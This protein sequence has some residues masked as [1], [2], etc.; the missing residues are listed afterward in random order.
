MKFVVDSNVLFTFFW[1][2]SVFRNLPV[3]LDLMLYSP[4]YA[5]EEI[6]KYA[7]EIIRKTGIS[8]EEFNKLK[9][10]LAFR[11][12]FISLTEYQLF[13]KKAK[14]LIQNS[15]ILSDIDFIALAIKLNCPIWSNDKLLKS[16]SKIDVLNTGDI[17]SLL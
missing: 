11:V 15:E 5:L 1:E 4:E 6:N 9:E 17:I 10:E 3:K 16:L 2:N 14:S 8:E 7:S 12:M 13:I